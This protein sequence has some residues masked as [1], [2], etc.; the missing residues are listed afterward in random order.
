MANF[1]FNERALKK[2]VKEGVEKNVLPAVQRALDDVY[3]SHKGKPVAE[4]KPVLQRRWARIGQ[5]YKLTDPHL[6]AYAEAISE[7]RRIRVR[8]DDLA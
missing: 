8:T 5:G 6:T 2:L 1:E 7:D 4:I 3:R